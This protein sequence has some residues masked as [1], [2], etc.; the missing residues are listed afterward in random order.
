MFDINTGIKF[1]Y[2]ENRKKLQYFKA[3]VTNDGD[4]F[5]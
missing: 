1:D 2:K 5:Y 3:L 4:T